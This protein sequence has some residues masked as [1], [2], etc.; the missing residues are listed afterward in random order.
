MRR[1]LIA[2]SLVAVLLAGPD[3]AG[4]QTRALP[5]AVQRAADALATGPVYV[6]AHN[7]A[8]VTRADAA[9]LRA[10]IRASEVP[11]YVAVFPPGAGEPQLLAATLGRALDRAGV[12]A[13]VAGTGGRA[14]AAGQT[15]A[16]G[17]QPGTARRAA[18]RALDQARGGSGPAVLDAFVAQLRRARE[19]GG[20]L[21]GGTPWWLWAL[22]LGALL[23][24]VA[25]IAWL[26]A[27]RRRADESRA[28]DTLRSLADEDLAAL[29]DELRALD[30]GIERRADDP[31]AREDYARALQAHAQA[32]DAMRLARRPR[33]FERVGRMLA[34]G[35]YATACV[36]ARLEGRARPERRPLCFFDPRHGPSVRDVPWA[37]ASG[38]P[39]EVPVC[40]VDAQRLERGQPPDVREIELADGG[41]VPFWSAPAW[42]APYASGLYGGLAG[43][44]PGGEGS[45]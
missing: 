33:D 39:R 10:E 32:S 45:Y 14:F 23:G 29:A 28:A 43:I 25:L 31:C 22:G 16:T 8:D 36:R 30:G 18:T 37:P 7:A 35:R 24:A 2:L 34:E 17:L 40:A 5:P 42:L 1:H 38:A 21:D 6:A 9:R 13:V 41:R 19:S 27:H 4:A 3:V 12:Y 26:R 15:G 20:T 44:E 11:T